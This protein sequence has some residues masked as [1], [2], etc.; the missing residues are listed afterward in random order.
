MN[1]RINWDQPRMFY[2]WRDWA[3]CGW[4][5]AYLYNHEPAAAIGVRL[6]GLAVVLN[7]ESIK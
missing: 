1:A 6:L 7:I 4:C 5:F 3:L 2:S